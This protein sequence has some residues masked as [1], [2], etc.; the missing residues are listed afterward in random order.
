VTA[1]FCEINFQSPSGPAT[2]DRVSTSGFGAT[3]SPG[4]GKLQASPNLL[5]P[6]A[7]SLNRA[8]G[9]R[10]TL[11]SHAFRLEKQ[12]FNGAWP[13]TDRGYSLARGRV[14]IASSL[15]G[16]HR[17]LGVN[18]W[19]FKWTGMKYLVLQRLFLI[20]SPGLPSEFLGLKPGQQA[21][22][23][24]VALHFNSAINSHSEFLS[25]KPGCRQ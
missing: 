11:I 4:S 8:D 1:R 24:A 9:E 14:F 5:P 2:R 23:T 6:L 17:W 16:A 10:I 13:G 18:Q 20:K 19:P 15:P 22:P 21:S 25:Q 12:I 7:A 3:Y